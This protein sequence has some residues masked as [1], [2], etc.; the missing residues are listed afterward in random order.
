VAWHFVVPGYKEME[1]NRNW[2]ALSEADRTYILSNP[3]DQYVIVA[4]VCL[5]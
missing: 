4:V 1:A 2:R 5:F 3:I